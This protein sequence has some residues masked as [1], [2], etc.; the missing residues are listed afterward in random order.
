MPANSAKRQF[1]GSKGIGHFL[2]IRGDGGRLKTTSD[3]STLQ[4]QI[5]ILLTN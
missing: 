2:G 5:S 4:K 3:S 1:L